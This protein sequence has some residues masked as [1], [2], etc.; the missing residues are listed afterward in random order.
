MSLNMLKTNNEYEITYYKRENFIDLRKEINKINKIFCK[1]LKNPPQCKNYLYIISGTVNHKEK[2]AIKL[3]DGNLLVRKMEKE[4][5]GDINEDIQHYYEY[6]E[7]MNKWCRID[8]FDLKNWFLKK[9]D[10]YFYFSYKTKFDYGELGF[11]IREDNTFFIDIVN[12]KIAKQIQYIEFE[13]CDYSNI[14]DYLKAFGQKVQKELGFSPINLEMSKLAMCKSI[15]E[16]KLPN[17][18][19]DFSDFIFSI[20]DLIYFELLDL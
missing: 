9:R 14:I 8:D 20:F 3:D 19:D 6:T 12:M 17:H 5:I 10:C 13:S 1:E 2:L 7:A 4:R 16:C 15:K 18:I 11:T